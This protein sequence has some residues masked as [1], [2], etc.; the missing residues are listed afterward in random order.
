MT[1]ATQTLPN[2][3]HK[4]GSAVARAYHRRAVAP[5]VDVFENADELL[6]VADVPGVRN[7]GIDLRVENDTLT[8]DAKRAYPSED[9]PAL[10]REYEEVDFS[11]TFRIP[12]GID[13]GGIS[14]ETKS[15][16]LVVRLPKAAAA[17]SRKIVVRSPG[18]E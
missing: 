7:D 10:S 16:T 4:N 1:D 18:R 15:G 8:L 5:P 14:A 2:D 12:A 9:S 6:I 13:T 3:K 17:K 11:T